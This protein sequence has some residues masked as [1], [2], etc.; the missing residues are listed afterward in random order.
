MKEKII[1]LF[2]V[3]SIITL[4]LTAVFSELSLSGQ[5][6]SEQFL[7]VFTTIIAFYFGVQF[8]KKS[9]ANPNKER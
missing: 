6:S 1:R 4:S 7:T 2:E 5:V 9:S 8:N 3:K